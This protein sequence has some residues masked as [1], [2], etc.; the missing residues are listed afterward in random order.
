MIAQ[1]CATTI[2]RRIPQRWSTFSLR[3]IRGYLISTWQ[4]GDVNLDHLVKVVFARC[5]QFKVQYFPCL[6]SLE[7]RLQVQPTLK[8]GEKWL[9]TT[10]CKKEYLMTLACTFQNNLELFCKEDLFLLHHSVMYSITYLYQYRFMYTLDYN[11]I[12]CYLFCCSNYS[13]WLLGS[14]FRMIPPSLWNFKH[15]FHFWYY[16]VLQTYFVFFLPQF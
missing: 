2:L 11:L 3:N 1:H 7:A 6:H 12:L 16:K 5:L 13:V 10:P 15:F 14:S 8:V 9:S 4:I